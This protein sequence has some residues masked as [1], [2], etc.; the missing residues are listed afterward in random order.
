MQPVDEAEQLFRVKLFST[1]QSLQNY[2]ISFTSFK[3]LIARFDSDVF[4]SIATGNT[5]F[6]FISN[7]DN[8]NFDIFGYNSQQT[9][10]KIV[11]MRCVKNGS[12]FTYTGKAV[13]YNQ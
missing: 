4:S 1:R 13:T 6:G 3:L 10:P 11:F 5:F 9:Y 7:H 12:N 8:K 2:L